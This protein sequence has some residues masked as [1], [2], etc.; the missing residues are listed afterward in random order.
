MLQETLC[1]KVNSFQSNVM[2][3]QIYLKKWSHISSVERFPKQ[4]NNLVEEIEEDE[5]EK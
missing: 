1:D 4:N 2:H 5:C 3:E